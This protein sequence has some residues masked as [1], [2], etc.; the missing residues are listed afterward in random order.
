MTLADFNDPEGRISDSK[1][2]S[3]QEHSR[4]RVPE[5]RVLQARFRGSLFCLLRYFRQTEGLVSRLGQSPYSSFTP[6]PDP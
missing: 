1:D 3:G 5:F 2:C 4:F 6:R